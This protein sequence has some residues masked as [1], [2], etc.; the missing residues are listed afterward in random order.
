MLSKSWWQIQNRECNFFSE[1]KIQ[2]R[3][4]QV[5]SRASRS[6]EFSCSLKSKKVIWLR[7]RPDPIE[8]TPQTLE[9]TISCTCRPEIRGINNASNPLRAGALWAEKRLDK[10]TIGTNWSLGEAVGHWDNSQ[11][12]PKPHQHNDNSRPID[13]YNS[14]STPHRTAL[15]LSEW[16]F[17]KIDWINR[18]RRLLASAGVP[19]LLPLYR[20]IVL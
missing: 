7:A 8:H 10:Y 12:T 13:G 19:L 5:K 18:T 6:R 17:K 4:K 3:E 20:W 14:Q 2:N 1:S 11:P 9:T 16:A 15:T